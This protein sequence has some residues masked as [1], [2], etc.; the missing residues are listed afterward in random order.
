MDF[1]RGMQE[2]QGLVSIAHAP[3]KSSEDT[4]SEEVYDATLYTAGSSATVS[5]AAVSAGTDWRAALSLPSKAVEPSRAATPGAEDIHIYVCTHGSRDCRCGDVG[6]DVV[7]TIREELTKIEDVAT[8]TRFKVFE[9]AHVGGHV[10]VRDSLA[11]ASPLLTL[12]IRWAANVLVYPSGDWFGNIRPK[13]IP[14]LL[15]VYADGASLER[16]SLF[17][18]HWRGRMG[19]RQDEQK[20]LH[21]K[22]TQPAQP[23]SPTPI[24]QPR[25][26]GSPTVPF[27]TW[28][29]K[30]MNVEADEGQTLMEIAKEAGLPSIEGVCDGK[31]EVRVA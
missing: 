21:L 20:E 13:D 1:K 10:Y 9:V 16:T 28:E 18:N 19:L 6:G 2:Y 31:L 5:A 24:L 12:R 14:A 7:D 23:P 29:G 8:R 27:L 22:A 30:I 11:S 25:D 26:R 4:G 17:A 3:G 15:K